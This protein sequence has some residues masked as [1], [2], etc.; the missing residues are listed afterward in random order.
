[1]DDKQSWVYAVVGVCCTLCQLMIMTWR[2]RQGWPNFGFHDDGRVVD[3][4][5][6]DRG[7]RWQRCG[8]YEGIWEIKGM[9]CLIGFGRPRIGVS[10]RG[11]G[12]R[13]CCIGDGKLTR[14]RHSLK[15]QFLMMISPIP[16]LISLSCP[17]LYHHLRTQSSVIALYL[18]MAWS[19]VNTEYSINR[20]QHTP[21]TA[22]I[23]HSIHWVLYWP[24]LTSSQDWLS[25]APSQ[26]LISWHTML[27]SILY[28]RTIMS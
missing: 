25:P 19:R 21:S 27:Y 5:Q 24:H 12:T 2:D 26:S 20:V 15:S 9:T 23:E 4:K 6:R 17:Q 16:S 13:T 1:M 8:G 11:I 18:S 10:T 28:I 7:G 22:Y 3:E 14:T